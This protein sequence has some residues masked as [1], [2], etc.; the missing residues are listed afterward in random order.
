M[1]VR[2]W[3]M[4]WRY[5]MRY[6]SLEEKRDRLTQQ[7][8]AGVRGCT[9]DSSLTGRRTANDFQFSYTI[10]TDCYPPVDETKFRN[11]DYCSGEKFWKRIIPRGVHAQKIVTFVTVV[12]YFSIGDCS[13]WSYGG[14]KL[15]FNEKWEYS[16]VGNNFAEAIKVHRAQL[17]FFLLL[18]N[19]E[20]IVFLFFFSK[21][22]QAK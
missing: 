21:Q 9:Q 15:Q 14:K 3:L 20:K 8:R 18:W 22:K 6:R 4:V 2:L 12:S 19:T 17:Q 1:L 16:R 10:F 7:V 5:L 11:H 13:S